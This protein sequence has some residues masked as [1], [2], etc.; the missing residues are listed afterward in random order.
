M[1]ICL[2]SLRRIIRSDVESFGHLPANMGFGQSDKALNADY[3]LQQS[4]N[5]SIKTKLYSAT[6][7][8]F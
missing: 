8:G 7:I 5:Q 4:I 6:N 3:F 2:S 1:V